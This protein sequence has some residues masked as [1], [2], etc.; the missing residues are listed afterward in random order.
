MEGF[1]HKDSFIALMAVVLAVFSLI[2]GAHVADAPTLSSTLVAGHCYSLFSHCW[3]RVSAVKWKFLMDLLLRKSF[4]SAADWQ[5]DD[6]WA[7]YV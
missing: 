5:H 4:D 1:G 3:D 6:A 7:L 2:G